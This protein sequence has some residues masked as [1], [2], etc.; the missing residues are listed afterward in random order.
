MYKL[1][2]VMQLT[3]NNGLAHAVVVRDLGPVLRVHVHNSVL[4]HIRQ[5]M[6]CIVILV[7]QELE[8][9]ELRQVQ[10]QG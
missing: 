4:P 6:T 2:R 3:L 8:R 7:V 1:T 10:H 5:I 9:L